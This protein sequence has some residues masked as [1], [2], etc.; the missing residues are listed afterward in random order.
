M[1]PIKTLYHQ[2]HAQCIPLS[3][4]SVFVIAQERWINC[5]ILTSLLD[6]SNIKAYKIMNISWF[7]RLHDFL[8]RW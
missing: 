3:S 4:R 2:P 7:L 5:E 1:L 6:L 8:G